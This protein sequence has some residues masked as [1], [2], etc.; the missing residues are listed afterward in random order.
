MREARRHRDMRDVIEAGGE[1]WA[2]RVAISDNDVS[3]SYGQLAR[4]ARQVAASL[5]RLGVPVGAY[6]GLIPAR[7]AESLVLYLALMAANAVPVVLPEM[8]HQILLRHAETIGLALIVNA[9]P[10]TPRFGSIPTTDWTNLCHERGYDA[11][12]RSRHDLATLTLTSGSTGFPKAVMV[13]H[14]NLLHYANGLL[15]R[16]DGWR[17]PLR[18]GNLTSLAADLGHTA[19]FPALLSGGS[20]QIADR[21]TA[22]DPARFWAWARQNELDL[23][24]STPSQFSAMMAGRSGGDWCFP[25]LILGG[26]RLPSPLAQSIFECGAASSL[27]NHYGPSETTVGAA[28]QLFRSSADLP[29]DSGDLPIGTGIGETSLHLLPLQTGQEG[30]GELAISGPGVTLGY[31]L[32]P[33]LNAARFPTMP[34]GERVYLTGDIFQRL[35]TGGLRFLGR[36]DRQI[37]VRGYAVDLDD[38]ERVIERDAAVRRAAAFQREVGGVVQIAAMVELTVDSEPCRHT[39]EILRMRLA[40][41]L[42]EWACPAFITFAA[43]IP[44][45]GN[46]KCDY[47]SAAKIIEQKLAGDGQ[48]CDGMEEEEVGIAGELTNRIVEICRKLLGSQSLAPSDDFVQAGL[49]SI[50]VMRL[51]SKLRDFG[52]ICVLEDIHRHGSAADLARHLERVSHQELPSDA[53]PIMDERRLSPIQ[54]WFFKLGLRRPN[55]WNQAVVLDSLTP[56]DVRG[57]ARAISAIRERHPILAQ[58][59]DFSTGSAVEAGRVDAPIAELSVTQLPPGAAARE[60][61][62][63]AACREGHRGMDLDQGR[64][65]KVH[66]FQS[67]DAADRILIIV[68][69][70]V[71]DGVSWRILM[72]DLL[73]A[74]VAARDGEVWPA[75]AAACFWDWTALL[76]DDQPTPR[77][78]PGLIFPSLALEVE[79]GV[80]PDSIVLALSEAQTTAF[81]TTCGTAAEFQATLAL[82]IADAVGEIA[83]TG[84]VVME[85]EAHGRAAVPGADRFYD[86]V[87]WFTEMRHVTFESGAGDTFAERLGPARQSLLEQTQDV[88]AINSP[89]LEV[90]FNLL[91]GFASPQCSDVRWH[92]GGHY[93]GPARSAADDCFYAVRVTG[94]TVDGRLAIDLVT[95]PR[96]VTRRTADRIL[97][98]IRERIALRTGCTPAKI[99]QLRREAGSTSGLVVHAPAFQTFYAAAEPKPVLITGGTGFLGAF[100]VD[101]MLRSG[102]CRP[103]CL[104]R[105]SSETHAR[106]RFLETFEHYFGDAAAQAAAERVGIYRGDVTENELGLHPGMAARQNI[107]AIFHLAADTRLVTTSQDKED[108]NVVAASRIIEWSAANGGIDLHYV[109]TLAVAGSIPGMPRLFD[110]GQFDF[111]QSFLSSYEAGKLEIERMV[112][113]TNSLRSATSIYRMGHLAA[114]SGTGVFQ[115]NI[116]ANRVYQM[117]RSYIL[118]GAAPTGPEGAIAFSNVDIVA[119]GL[120]AFSQADTIPAGTFH[121][122]T[123]YEIGMATIVKWMNGFGYSIDLLAPDEYAARLGGLNATGNDRSLHAAAYWTNRKPRN[124]RYDSSYSQGLFKELELEFPAPTERWFYRLLTHA[125]DARFFPSP[126]RPHSVAR[127]ASRHFGTEAVQI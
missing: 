54:R 49:D 104:V 127:P 79:G 65:M 59:F 126:G 30:T 6:V 92:L 57:L 123:P 17:R 70:L 76:L 52:L 115:R 61:A 22:R 60:V 74:Y 105:G 94:R 33:K 116:A 15:D 5:D 32:Q 96:R 31:C 56:I 91:G 43:G 34:N 95:D 14:T 21:A 64:L 40:E 38:V 18:F 75:R 19:I 26:E 89:P 122:E 24:K 3:F 55:H 81:T 8:P 20:V 100:L 78:V 66:L 121:L 10:G 68:H 4:H 36:I 87:G 97:L 83:N 113:A 125:V 112:R 124:I 42:P 119:E 102:D 101:A 88:I 13:T 109:S 50:L 93:C 9:V 111:G 28:C 44:V 47:A 45:N 53:K 118:A 77:E 27:V 82:A 86:C 39:P 37:K 62:F 12:G 98:R 117:L 11:S 2:E 16:I 99:G 84:S 120:L 35:A 29:A 110:E 48:S 73:A 85:V 114:H 63:E 23:I 107:Q 69:H 58:A 71:T 72:D 41:Q 1:L 90:C 106:N 67:Q 108:A 7:N 80:S 25:I 51:I 46:G 103:V